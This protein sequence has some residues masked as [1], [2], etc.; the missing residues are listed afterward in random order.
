MLIEDYINKLKSSHT[1]LNTAIPAKEIS[2][3]WDYFTCEECGF[4]CTKLSPISVDNM[5]EIASHLVISKKEFK[6]KYTIIHNRKR[7]FPMPCPFYDNGC[8]IYSV[9]PTVCRMYPVVNID[10]TVHISLFC[11]AMEGLCRKILEQRLSK[12]QLQ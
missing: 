3:V 10:K 7:C 1:P 8:K 11:K 4:C 2:K 12:Y 9:R 5:S 6:S